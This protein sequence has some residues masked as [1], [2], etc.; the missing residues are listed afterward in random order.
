MAGEVC[1]R[2]FTERITSKGTP[3]CLKTENTKE[4]I[5]HTKE[6]IKLEGTCRKGKARAFLRDSRIFKVLRTN[7]ALI[8]H[9]REA[10][11]IVLEK[12]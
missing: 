3:E 2:I 4:E 10:G 12:L 9:R 7:V 8:Y 6:R 5:R 11:N 1:A